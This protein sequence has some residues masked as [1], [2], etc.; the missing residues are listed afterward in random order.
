MT[1]STNKTLR[2]NP[3]T[4]YRDPK[5]GQWLIVHHSQSLTIN[6]SQGSN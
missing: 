5:T 2:Q 4:A 3:F 1:T 6:Q